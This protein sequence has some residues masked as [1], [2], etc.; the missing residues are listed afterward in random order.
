MTYEVRDGI[1]NH[2]GIGYA[3]TLEGRIVRHAD[4][5]AYVN[6]DYDDAIRAG[7]LKEDEIPKEV[8]EVLGKSKTERINTAVL[9]LIE[10]N[11]DLKDITFSREVGRV[12]EDFHT[13]MFEQVYRNP[14]AKGQEGKA[15][16][17]LA[18]LY[19]HYMK[20]EKELPP[21]YKSI[22]ETE[23]LGRAV[24]DYVACMTDRYALERF[25]DIYIPLNWQV[26]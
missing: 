23:G 2:V 5:I 6:H 20:H 26:L 17:M 1:L 14:I 21:E 4:R 3:T 12:M 18:I 24:C 8:R 13:F 11:T 16:D 10:N 7:I 15:Q 22:I 19:Q 9:D 25:K